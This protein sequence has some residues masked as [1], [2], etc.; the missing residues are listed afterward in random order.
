MLIFATMAVWFACIAAHILSSCGRSPALFVGVS[1]AS[2]DGN[3]GGLVG[4]DLV[5][6]HG[7]GNSGN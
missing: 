3:F 6:Y 7:K 5:G 4:L 1:I 2:V